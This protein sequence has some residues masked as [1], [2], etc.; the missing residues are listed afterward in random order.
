M[1]DFNFEVKYRQ[2]KANANADCLSRI[3]AHPEYI[4]DTLNPP[5]I[6]TLS[7]NVENE[8]IVAQKRDPDILNIRQQLLSN[9]SDPDLHEKYKINQ[10]LLQISFNDE[11]WLTMVPQDIR[12][13]LL[14]KYHDAILGGHRSFRKTYLHLRKK[15]Y[16][17]TLRQDVKD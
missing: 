6:A 17:K 2:G 13:I 8:M 11:N 9:A 14:F 3:K 7:T 4:I 1:A 5:A 15:Y 12:K 16:W 10:D